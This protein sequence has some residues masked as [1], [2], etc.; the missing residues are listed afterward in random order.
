MVG[1]LLTGAFLAWVALRAVS[2][3]LFGIE[4]IDPLTVLSVAAILGSAAMLACLRPALRA[5][6]TDPATALRSD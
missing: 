3:L 1:G 6:R 4:S 2:S 5:G